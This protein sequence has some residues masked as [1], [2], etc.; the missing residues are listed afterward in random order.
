MRFSHTGGTGGLADRLQQFDGGA[1]VVWRPAELQRCGRNGHSGGSL[2]CS[3]ALTCSSCSGCPPNAIDRAVPLLSAAHA[4]AFL[5]TLQ[6]GLERIYGPTTLDEVTGA[7][8]AMI[9]AS[10]CCS[11]A[12]VL[13]LCETACVA[14]SK[15]LVAGPGQ[16]WA[17]APCLGCCLLKLRLPA[18]VTCGRH[19]LQ[20]CRHASA[21]VDSQTVA[22]PIV[23]RHM[24][25]LA[26]LQA[27]IA[28]A[29]CLCAGGKPGAE[30][31]ADQFRIPLRRGTVHQQWQP[32]RLP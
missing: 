24:V 17:H 9:M 29:S 25:Q 8:K 11:S 4:E 5:C 26:P 27:M 10:C 2:Q 32:A 23:L 30:R 12:A 13:L 14:V 1:G 18:S 28:A 6:Y 7:N 31:A 16:W 15:R 21:C 19:H 20:L 22:C 3:P